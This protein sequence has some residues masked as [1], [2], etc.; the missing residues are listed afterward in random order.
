[1]AVTEYKLEELLILQ[2]LE[3]IKRTWEKELERREKTKIW[4]TVNYDNVSKALTEFIL[5]HKYGDIVRLFRTKNKY[6]QNHLDKIITRI[7]EF[8]R[9][10]NLRKIPKQLLIELIEYEIQRKILLRNYVRNYR[11]PYKYPK[12]K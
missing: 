8:C 9:K 4:I 10:H 3:Y 11:V 1:M 12:S 6:M 5:T 7:I 2:D